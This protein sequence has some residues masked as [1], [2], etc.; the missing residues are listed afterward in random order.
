MTVRELINWLKDYSDD[1]E[2]VIGC[3][4][5]FGSNFIYD[6]EDIFKS[7]VSIFYNEFDDDDED[8]ESHPQKVILL[9]S[10]QLGTFG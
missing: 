10:S 4:Q 1:A 9:E 6:V 7:E 2:V 5:S 3:C 8:N